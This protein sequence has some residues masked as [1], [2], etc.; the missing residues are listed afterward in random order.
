MIDEITLPEIIL[1]IIGSFIIFEGLIGAGSNMAI[2]RSA[3][4]RLN[5]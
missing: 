4:M 3:E 1:M 2:L 5:L